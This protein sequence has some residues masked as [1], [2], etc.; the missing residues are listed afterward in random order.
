MNSLLNKTIIKRILDFIMTLVLLSL[1]AFQVTGQRNHEWIGTAMFCICILLC[2]ENSTKPNESK[3][4][5]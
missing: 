1:M 2:N 4:E 5:K 3:S